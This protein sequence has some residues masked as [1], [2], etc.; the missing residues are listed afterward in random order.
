MN[1]KLASVIAP[2]YTGNAIKRAVWTR[3]AEI[4]LYMD[5]VFIGRRSS[6]VQ[7]LIREE[8]NQNKENVIVL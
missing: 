4:K 3:S 7:S 6:F 8:S 1:I 5:E 2:P